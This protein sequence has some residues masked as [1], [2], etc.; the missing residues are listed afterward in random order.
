MALLDI[1]SVDVVKSELDIF[2]LPGTQTSVETTRV[3][4]C[5]PV[6]SIDSG[7]ITFHY[8]GNKIKTFF[9]LKNSRSSECIFFQKA[10]TELSYHH[11]H[12]ILNI[13]IYIYFR[14]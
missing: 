8:K 4:A 6:T 5:F 10:N 9:Q 12:H 1:G 11:H 2:S 13:Y 3:E 14:K 7:P